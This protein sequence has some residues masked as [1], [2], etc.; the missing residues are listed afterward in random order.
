MCL[1]GGDAWSK[2]HEKILAH[3]RGLHYDHVPGVTL[4]SADAPKQKW[5]SAMDA[6]NAWKA[7]ERAKEASGQ[8]WWQTYRGDS[9]GDRNPPGG[10]TKPPGGGTKPP[11][12]GSGP[13]DWN[14]PD[15]PSGTGPYPDDNIYFPML[16][17]D[18]EAPKAQNWAR[19]MPRGQQG[20]NVRPG[21]IWSGAPDLSGGPVHGGLLYQPW[22][23]NYQHHFVPDNLWDYRPPE[24][25]V[26][27]PKFYQNPLGI[28]DVVHPE[29]E[30]ETPP[31]NPNG[32]PT[33]GGPD[34]P[35][36]DSDT[37]YQGGYDSLAD[38]VADLF[39]L[40]DFNNWG[41]PVF[42]DDSDFGDATDYG[43]PGW[44][45]EAPI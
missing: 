16:V 27:R 19:Y 30:P 24:L 26:G 20:A 12:G 43:D 11:G 6:F 3:A 18:Y 37:G 22:T 34:R 42:G 38:A 29:P 44:G 41:D 10:G 7:R 1:G 45:G 36:A 40:Q 9:G 23:S 4:P 5:I 35:G 14:N 17:P 33:P 31:T 21:D 28:L 8:A 39:G 15:P 32:D 13:P 2:D 25:K